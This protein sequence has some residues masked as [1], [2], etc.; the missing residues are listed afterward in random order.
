MYTEA[1]FTSA[2]E[3]PESPLQNEKK[4]GKKS[5]ACCAMLSTKHLVRN[6]MGPIIVNGNRHRHYFQISVSM[7]E[8]KTTNNNAEPSFRLL[9]FQR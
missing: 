4:K 2:S 1:R 9:A 8:K 5:T 6:P 7:M 3:V